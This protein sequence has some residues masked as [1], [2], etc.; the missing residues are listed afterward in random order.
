MWE[1]SFHKIRED[2]KS[3]LKIF[4][5]TLKQLRRK[6]PTRRNIKIE[7]A[8]LTIKEDIMNR[9][10]FEKLTEEN[11]EEEEKHTMKAKYKRQS[12][13]SITYKTERKINRTKTIELVRIY[14]ERWMKDQLN[15]RVKST[16]DK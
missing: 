5:G 6:K 4:P 2:F 9:E 12:D 11:Q 3:S 14:T 7:M 10:H 8:I 15:F 16:Q 13:R 1:D